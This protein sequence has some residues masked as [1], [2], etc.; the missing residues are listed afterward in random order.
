MI[1]PRFAYFGEKN[2]LKVGPQYNLQN[3]NI[4][5]LGNHQ[6]QNVSTEEQQRLQGHECGRT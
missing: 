1:E 4:E 6:G 3:S 2:T 5:I